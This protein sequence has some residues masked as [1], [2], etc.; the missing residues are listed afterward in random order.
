MW[1][2]PVSTSKA[3]RALVSLFA[4]GVSRSL[5]RHQAGLFATGLFTG[6]ASAGLFAIGLFTGQVSTGLFA[7]GLFTDIRRSLCYRSLYRHQAGLFATG[8]FTGQ[9]SGRSLCYR[10]LYRHQAGLFFLRALVGLIPGMCRLS[11]GILSEPLYR[12]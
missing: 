8:L 1:C 6:Q 3:S 2:Q 4:R 12:H 11:T 7:I 9:A 10:S 5:Y